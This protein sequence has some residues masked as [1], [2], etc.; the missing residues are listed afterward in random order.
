MSKQMLSCILRLYRSALDVG[1]EWQPALSNVVSP[2][3]V[4]WGL[5]DE[6][7]PATFADQLGH[8]TKARRILKLE[9]GHWFPLQGPEE[10]AKALKDHWAV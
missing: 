2:G 1:S 6:G 9:T 3:L 4:L 7:C 10:V 8:D 5:K